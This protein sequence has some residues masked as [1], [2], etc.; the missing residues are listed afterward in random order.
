[1]IR[2]FFVLVVALAALT[3]CRVDIDV[4]V[5]MAQNGSG[6]VTVEAVADA[7]VVAAAP[8]LVDDLRLD[9]LRV[10]GWAIEGPATTPDGGVRIVV[11][12]T[13][14]TPEQATAL[15]ASLNGSEGPLQA[16]LL[17]RDATASSITYTMTGTAALE[18]GL[19]SFADPDLLAAVGA[20]PYADSIRE[21]GISADDTVTIS[22]SAQL[23]GEVESTTGTETVG[24][25]LGGTVPSELG[26]VVSWSVP[27]D[28]TRVDLATITRAS[29]ERGGIWSP[30]ATVALIALIVWVV[31]SVV[32]VA[33]VVRRRRR[34]RRRSRRITPSA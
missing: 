19:E 7:A 20:A 18:A 16:V 34:A 8:G 6:T 22:L 14:S 10:A 30:L 32:L 24:G 9:D 12:H 13:F 15:L 1:M 11:R 33:F 4:D 31:L 21:A 2:R 17:A 23:P 28:G 26:S 3:G 27:T 29:L 5:T 25:T